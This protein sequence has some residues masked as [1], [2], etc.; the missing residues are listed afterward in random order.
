MIIESSRILILGANGVLGSHISELLQRKGA[1]IVGTARS[2]ESSVTLAANLAERLI[3]D[4]NEPVSIATLASYLVS[5][6]LPLD[7]VI[8]AAG[9]VGFGTVDVTSSQMAA[10][11]MQVNH[12]GPAELITQLL[13]ALKKSAEIGNTPIVVGITGVVA[14]RAF[15][16]MAAYVASKTAH[17]A[18]LAALALEM[19]RAKIRVLDAHPGHT[20]TGLAGRAVF[21][22][23][24]KFPQGLTPEHVAQVIVNAIELDS[25][26][27]SSADF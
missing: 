27:L 15:P 21:G 7:G 12:L 6:E 5:S 24:P 26:S 8:N 22:S 3:L 13:P 11:L 20:E 4:L 1:Q 16:G 14:E 10:M 19:R 23:A 25:T 2:N 9:V 17:A 18:W